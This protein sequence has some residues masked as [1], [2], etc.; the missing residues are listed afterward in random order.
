[1]VAQN[2]LGRHGLD[3]DFLQDKE[4]PAEGLEI[5]NSGETARTVLSQVAFPHLQLQSFLY[6]LPPDLLQN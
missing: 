6:N 4:F 5:G 3:V 2:K 1:M